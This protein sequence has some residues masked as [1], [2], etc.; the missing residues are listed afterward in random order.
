MAIITIDLAQCPDKLDVV[1]ALVD[2]IHFIQQRRYSFEKIWS[3]T[4]TF[5]EVGLS[6]AQA[7]CLWEL[8]LFD[9]SQQRSE[10]DAL[11]KLGLTCQIEADGIAWVEIDRKDLRFT[12]EDRWLL[13][14]EDTP[15]YQ[16]LDLAVRAALKIPTRG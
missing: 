11:V 14:I 9:T 16:Y 2:E 7:N 10:Y 1:P 8:L 4:Q 6:R 15:H 5:Q 3:I 12:P 13:G